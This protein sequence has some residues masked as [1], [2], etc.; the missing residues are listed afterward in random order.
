MG[1]GRACRIFTLM[2][3]A[4]GGQS[5]GT[6]GGRDPTG[7]GG[8][9]TSGVL[10]GSGG[11]TDASAA[12]AG[13]GGV[14]Q[15]FSPGTVSIRI[16]VA[17]SRSFCWQACGPGGPEIGILDA[18]GHV[19]ELS[20]PPCPLT[21]CPVCGE[22]TCSNFCQPYSAQ[23]ETVALDWDGSFIQA[24]PCDNGR[25][26]GATVYAPAGNYTAKFCSAPGTLSTASIQQ[27]DST[28]PFECVEVPFSFPSTT[29]VTGTLGC[30]VGRAA[31]TADADC[32]DSGPGGTVCNNGIC[33]ARP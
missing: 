11:S 26:C 3:T 8:G 2:V 4:C 13:A 6:S 23:L 10:F 24:T 25:S 27:C 20:L 19:L 33:T 14:G 5:V 29:V 31:C 7:H 15:T 30:L 22:I 28:G 18:K 17:P 12:G 16:T 9:G 32:C 1:W 21:A